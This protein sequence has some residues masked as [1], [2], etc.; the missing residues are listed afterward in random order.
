MRQILILTTVLIAT[1]VYSQSHQGP[2][3]GSY[4]SGVYVTTNSFTNQPVSKSP[5]FET[6]RN[7]IKFKGFPYSIEHNEKLPGE[8]EIYNE[9]GVSTEAGGVALIKSFEGNTESN[10]IPPDPHVAV[11]PDHVVGTVNSD[12]AIWDKN[13]NLLKRIDAGNWYSSFGVDPFDPKV[14]Y[15]HFAQRWVMVWLD[16][17]DSP[18]RGYIMISVS[19]DSN[20]LGTWRN[21]LMPSNIN[22]TTTT[23]NWGDY[24]GVGFDEENFLITSNQFNF[25]GYFDYAKIRVIKKSEIYNNPTDTCKWYDFWNIK[26]PGNSQSVFNIRP[27]IHFTPSD[28]SYFVHIPYYSSNAYVIYRVTYDGNG[29]PALSGTAVPVTAYSDP[30]QALQPGGVALESSGP[31]L[32]NEPV[33]RDGSIWLTHSTRNPT[34]GSFSAVR[35][36]RI[37]PFT[38]TPIEQLTFGTPSTWYF[39]PAIMIDK[40]GNMVF[41]VSRS[42]PTEYVSAYYVGK[43]NGST[44]F[45]QPYLLMPGKGQYQKD[46]GSGRNRWG[47]YLGISLDPSGE[48]F[49][50]MSEY[51]AAPSVWSNRIGEVR[52]MP[53]T[54]ASLLTDIPKIDFQAME[55]GREKDTITFQMINVGS[56]Q[57]V[58]NSL[59]LSNSAFSLAGQLT[60]PLTIN[61]FDSL[62]ISVVC[63]PQIAGML[64]DTLVLVDNDP[65]ENRIPVRVESFDLNPVAPQKILV[66]TN[67][68]NGG[69]TFLINK[70]TGES[71]LLG[72]AG[73][74]TFSSISANPKSGVIY[75]FKAS[76]GQTLLHKMDANSG[77][78]Y[79]RTILE[80]SDVTGSAFDTSG[81]LYLVS[82]RNLLYKY[83]E[84]DNSIIR[85]DSVKCTVSA[86]AFDP[87]NNLLFASIYKPLGADKDKILRII[88]GTGD[89]LRIGN[90]GNNKP[91][92][93]LF[94]D[95]T[96][97]LFGFTGVASVSGEFTAINKSNGV[98]T[99]IGSTGLIGLVSA[100]YYPGVIN[101]INETGDG[102]TIS[103]Y[104]LFDNYPNPFNPSTVIRFSM[105]VSGMVTL[106]VYNTLG[107]KVAVL[108]NGNM[109]AGEHKVE[110]DASGLTSGV[111]FC[112]LRTGDFRSMKKMVLLR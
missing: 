15:D 6:V 98:G 9:G 69:G 54:G 53:V 29:V 59:G 55:R 45:T 26:Y 46:Y 66:V 74:T 76:G 71:T 70:S 68:T 75:G 62:A 23:S 89:T 97:G 38:S 3:L 103:A 94:F 100:A 43:Q 91:V 7:K 47:D 12:F 104:K 21:W 106:Q 40:G 61:S 24:Q 73:A 30:P 56:Q 109:N 65:V 63:D 77:K 35:M 78:L 42:S 101:S 32:T 58:I 95:E 18:Q 88:Q 79:S 111:Y 19:D 36:A 52:M 96:A 108:I 10:S 85:T 44:T 83:N 57:L 82:K 102:S 2:A 93:S 80:L 90:L 48:T 28:T 84:T 99:V 37:N 107:E 20:P 67:S 11:G 64:Y 72:P 112:E 8:L 14:V 5:K 81:T 41:T 49:W 87:L 105:P 110:F 4:A 25:G 13:G 34:S 92:R 51:V 27:V 17:R 22:G 60:Y 86:I 39:Y 16:Q 1:S 50:M 31:Q 33:Y